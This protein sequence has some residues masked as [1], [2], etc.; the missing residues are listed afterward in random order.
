MRGPGAAA[1]RQTRQLF[2]YSLAAVFAMAFV[3]HL[4]AQ[5]RPEVPALLESAPFGSA[6]PRYVRAVSYRY[7]FASPTERRATGSVWARE[8][9]VPFI[10][11]PPRALGTK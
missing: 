9:D 5:A 7:R 2:T 4:S 1:F 6:P 8:P 11:L 10:Y 3:S